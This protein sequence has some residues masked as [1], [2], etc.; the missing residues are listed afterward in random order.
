MTTPS[1][2][3]SARPPDATQLF[4]LF[5]FL[6]ALS[7]VLHQLWWHGFEV[8]SVH[9]LVIV[10]ALWTAQRPTSVG[11]FLTMIAAEVLSVSLDMPDVGSH[12]LLVLVSG[13]SVLAYV[14]WTTLATRRLPDAGT[15]FERIAPFLRVQLLVV[16]VA[17]AIAKMNTGFF[18]GEVSCAVALSGQVVWFAPGFL[19]GAW[20]VDPSV[21]GTV[22]I[23]V[24]LPVLLA[25][26][27]TRLVGLIVGGAFHMVLAMAGNVPFSAL[28]LALYVGFLPAAV[29]SRLRALV[30]ARPG[31]GRWTRR[32]RGLARSP[33]ALPV[34]VG[35]WLAAAVVFSIEPAAGRVLISNGTRLVV[36]AVGLTAGTLLALGLAHGGARA[37][38]PRS[39]RLG[40]PLFAAGILL[41]VAN[42]L[43]PYLGLKTESSFTMFS[44]LQTEDGRWNHALIPEAVRIFPYQDQLVRVT[45]SNDQALLARSRGGTRLVRFELERY[46]R[47][48]PGTTA[49]YAE[50]AAGGETTRTTGSGAAPS[51][52]TAVVDRLVKFRPVR[53]PERA[54]C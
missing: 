50:L 7:L 28:A 49:T 9:F 33:A 19:D 11:R 31:L 2:D 35:C 39:L 51:P 54:G 20:R 47:A 44:N 38:P 46:L 16:Y 24:T 18:D 32:A 6:F 37:H 45:D 1:S 36:V 42:S 22:A 21:W 41:L 14:G 17:A 25:V 30:A 52:A 27:R 53:A 29:S 15:L 48:H 43:S 4:G 3:R 26:P 5:A 13:A 34:A 40:H 23:E 8:L 10:A 12:T